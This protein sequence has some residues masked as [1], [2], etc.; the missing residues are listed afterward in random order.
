VTAE[1]QTHFDKLPGKPRVYDAVDTS[2][3]KAGQAWFKTLDRDLQ[4]FEHLSLKVGAQ[5]MLL[6]NLSPVGRCRVTL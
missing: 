2:S 4:C 3:S 6:S 1:N 5:V